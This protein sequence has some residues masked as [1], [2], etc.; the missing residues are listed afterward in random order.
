MKWNI[1][2]N[3]NKITFLGEFYIFPKNPNGICGYSPHKA[4]RQ[5]QTELKF[6]KLKNLKKRKAKRTSVQ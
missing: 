3:E 1:E 6:P 4:K 5:W 2:R